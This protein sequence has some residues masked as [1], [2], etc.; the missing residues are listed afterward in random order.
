MTKHIIISL[1]DKLNHNKSIVS[2]DDS[3]DELSGSETKGII[4]WE[5]FLL[6][7]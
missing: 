5:Q 2:D 3:C 6:Y 4:R 1:K 7:N